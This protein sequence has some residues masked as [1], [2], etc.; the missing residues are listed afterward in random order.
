MELDI[1]NRNAYIEYILKN[2][3]EKRFSVCDLDKNYN[4]IK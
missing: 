4:K 3:V 1:V 2:K